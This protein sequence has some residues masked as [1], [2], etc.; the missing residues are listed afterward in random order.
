MMV[1][2][3]IELEPYQVA[4]MVRNYL[5]YLDIAKDTKNINIAVEGDLN[6]ISDAREG[7]F[8]STWNKVTSYLEIKWAEDK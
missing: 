4:E 8:Y 5:E 6:L 2:K 3:S 7:N 1:R